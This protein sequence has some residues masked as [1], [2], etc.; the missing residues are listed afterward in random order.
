MIYYQFVS[1]RENRKK[2][3]GTVFFFQLFSS[4]S[5]GRK[6]VKEATLSE[7]L[8]QS[9]INLNETLRSEGVRKTREEEK[10]SREISDQPRER[11]RETGQTGRYKIKFTSAKKEKNRQIDEE[12]RKK[13]TNYE[14]AVD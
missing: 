1:R 13:R 2:I 9:T 8:L 4:S 11:E 3:S 7:P 10:K 6:F 12:P 5:W 14:K